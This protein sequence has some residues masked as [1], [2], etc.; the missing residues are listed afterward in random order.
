MSV[1]IA[2]ELEWTRALLRPY[3]YVGSPGSETRYDLGVFRP[4]IPTRDIS[5]F[6][7]VYAITAHSLESSLNQPIVRSIHVPPGARYLDEA[8]NLIRPDYLAAIQTFA[9]S[10]LDGVA[11]GW[12]I[13]STGSTAGH[14]QSVQVAEGREFQRYTA[15]VSPGGQRRLYHQVTS[16]RVKPG[17]SYTIRVQTKG[18]RQPNSRH[19]LNVTFRDGPKSEA[20]S[21]GSVSVELNAG[22]AWEERRLLFTPPPGVEWINF[23][24]ILTSVDASTALTT[25]DVFRPQFVETVLAARIYADPILSLLTTRSALEWPMNATTTRL[26][27]IN[28]LL[29]ATGCGPLW[30]DRNGAYRMTPLVDPRSQPAVVTYNA[31]EMASDV[32]R[33]GR[34]M[35][36]DVG[37]VPN[38]W[39]FVF[40][41]PSP[42]RT[43][44]L[45]PGDGLYEITNQSDGPMSIK[46]RNGLVVSRYYELDAADQYALVAQGTE[47]V[48]R[49]RSPE[50]AYSFKVAPIPALWHHDVIVYT[51]GAVE[52]DVDFAEPHRCVVD[53]WTLP[54]DGGDLSLSVTEVTATRP[55]TPQTTD[56][57]GWDRYADIGDYRYFIWDTVGTFGAY[58]IK[59]GLVDIEIIGG[60]GQGGGCSEYTGY[61][62][63]GGGAAGQRR[64]LT[65]VMV[66]ADVTVVIGKGGNSEAMNVTGETGGQS[67]WGAEIATGGV[68]GGGGF[69][70]GTAGWNGAGAGH[71]NS[72]GALL[73]GA[74]ASG[75]NGGDGYS[76]DAQGG[77]GGGGAGEGA[78]GQH[79]AQNFA[80]SGGIGVNDLPG[81][82]MVCAGGGGGYAGFYGGGPGQGG[83]S[84]AGDGGWTLDKPL[85]NG[86]DAT[87]FGNGGGGGVISVYGT[88]AR[89]GFGSRGRVIVKALLE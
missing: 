48:A 56:F 83:S 10:D 78:S 59:P 85:M 13:D 62:A 40:A 57:L 20:A 47:I 24:I 65:D 26:E 1:T 51:D 3:V 23:T 74:G 58:V 39:V 64:V 63:G 76:L 50:R 19:Y 54:L 73:G 61:A 75:R 12:I 5:Q 35:S 79:A 70:Q 41:D 37:S 18:V 43:E 14:A 9:D 71:P 87:G 22:P 16:Y 80:G 86:G 46:G 28:K 29:G 52:G 72:N 55:R 27:I 6:R 82:T 2:E 53:G 77:F 8:M 32:T 25:L 42:D 36:Q 44:P 68:G 31:D 30:V 81:I 66:T 34:S 45:Y 88:F 67:S 84:A 38:R 7:P 60:G 69:A 17:I 33:E 89:G 15:M 11:D 21:V 49:D 4:E